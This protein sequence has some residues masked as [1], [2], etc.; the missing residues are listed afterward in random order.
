MRGRRERVDHNYDDMSDEQKR[1]YDLSRAT[2]HRASGITVRKVTEV[3][4]HRSTA[5]ERQCPHNYREKD[6]LQQTKSQAANAKEPDPQSRFIEKNKADKRVDKEVKRIYFMRFGDILNT[7]ISN[8]E[9][10]GEATVAVGPI[11]W[12]DARTG[13]DESHLVDIPISLDYFQVWWIDNV[14]T[15]QRDEWKLNSFI[16]SAVGKLVV[17]VLGNNCVLRH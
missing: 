11:I 7:A 1:A 8:L 5:L 14:V 12:N 6:R 2:S 15:K 16:Q 4:P 9:E 13:K 17:N 3:H 10:A